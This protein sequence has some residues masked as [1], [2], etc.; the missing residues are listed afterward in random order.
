MHPNPSPLP[1]IIKHFCLVLLIFLFSEKHS[2]PTKVYIHSGAL[3][4]IKVARTT[5]RRMQ[6]KPSLHAYQ[7]KICPLCLK[8]Q[9]AFTHLNVQYYLNIELETV[10]TPEILA[11]TD[12]ILSTIH[13]Y[14]SIGVLVLI[15]VVL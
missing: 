5:L 3:H 10:C 2:L 1:F 9:Q 15:R 13:M 11:Y 6:R 14:S 7:N 12:C 8:L 4:Y